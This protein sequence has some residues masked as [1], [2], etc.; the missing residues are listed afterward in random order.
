M[1][2]LFAFQIFR[3]FQR[4]SFLDEL[5]ADIFIYFCFFDFKQ[6]SKNLDE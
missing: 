3:S 6:L 4:L 1:L 5:I 2:L